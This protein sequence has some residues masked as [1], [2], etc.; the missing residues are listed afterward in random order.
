MTAIVHTGGCQCGAVRFRVEGALGDA[1]VCHCRMCQKA[2]G[3]FY[4]PLVSV[5]QA[6]LVWTRGEPK[7]FQS[8]NAAS[9]GFCGDCGTPLTY[10]APD[11]VALTIAAFDRPEGIVPTIQWGIEAKLPYVDHIPQLP[12][13]DTMADQD[14]VSFLANLVS[15]QHPDHDTAEWPPEE[16]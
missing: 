13:D 10:E 15:Y 4:L 5:R 16:R 1:S 12:G 6:K 8:S 2:A 14:A 3:N 7:R 11:G 9:R